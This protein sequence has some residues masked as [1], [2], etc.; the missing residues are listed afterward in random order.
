MLPLSNAIPY[1]NDPTENAIQIS[2]EADGN[3]N[4]GDFIL[5]C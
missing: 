4:N 1:P 3:F 5:L 2:G